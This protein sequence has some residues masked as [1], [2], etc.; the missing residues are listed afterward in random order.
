MPINWNHISKCVLKQDTKKPP[1][2]GFFYVPVD[3]PTAT[4]EAQRDSG[5]DYSTIKTPT[6]FASQENLFKF[7]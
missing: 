4:T 3:L 2:G 6:R 1:S 7:D 5:Y